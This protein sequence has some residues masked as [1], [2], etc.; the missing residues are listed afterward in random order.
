MTPLND[1]LAAKRELKRWTRHAEDAGITALGVGL[2][3]VCGKLLPDV[4]VQVYV[5]QKRTRSALHS[6]RRLPAN[7]D[8]LRVDVIQSCPAQFM[9]GSGRPSPATIQRRVDAANGRTRVRPLVGGVSCANR[10]ISSGTLGY[11]ATSALPSD[12]PES[13]YLLSTAHVFG[14]P[15]TDTQKRCVVQAAPADGGTGQ[16][17]VAEVARSV[18]PS[19]DESNTI[20]AAIAKVRPGIQ[21]EPEILGI[22][23]VNDVT[24]ATLGEAVQKQ[25]RTT[26]LTAG[27]VVS[28]A[29]ETQVNFQYRNTDRPHAFTNQI[30]I[31]P[32]D[33]DRPFALFGDSGALVVTEHARRAVGLYFAGAYDGS[34]GLATPITR[35]QR[36][37]GVRLL[38]TVAAPQREATGEF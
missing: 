30:R 36:S 4:G 23:A 2:T 8:G 1:Y 5:Q 29:Y 9:G 16:S 19:P 13:V 17:V 11:F 28:I 7:L 6:K 20:D 34:Y 18:M 15:G 3:K 31:E 38:R 35:I 10:F 22:G 33:P 26:G 32:D 12:D 14:P 25:G 27:N 37:L 24:K 21:I